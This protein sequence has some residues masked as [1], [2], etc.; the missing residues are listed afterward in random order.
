MIFP[1]VTGLT[2]SLP[3]LQGMPDIDLE[4]VDSRLYDGRIQQLVYVPS[5]R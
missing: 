2:G 1:V 4:L 3:I 5:L